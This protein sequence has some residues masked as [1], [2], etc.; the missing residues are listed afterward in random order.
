MERIISEA[1]SILKDPPEPWWPPPLLDQLCHTGP[2]GRRQHLGVQSF[3]TF[4]VLRLVLCK[5]SELDNVFVSQVLVLY[6]INVIHPEK[7]NI[8][9]NVKR[10]ALL[11]PYVHIHEKVEPLSIFLASPLVLQVWQLTLSKALHLSVEGFQYF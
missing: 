3:W 4:E 6:P 10:R 9:Y 7:S 11:L 2:L 8:Y 5:H 1:S